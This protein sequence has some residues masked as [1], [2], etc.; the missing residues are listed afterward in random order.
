MRVTVIQFQFPVVWKSHY[1]SLSPCRPFLTAS[2]AHIRHTGFVKEEL[3]VDLKTW[4]C[5]TWR[6]RELSVR[7]LDPGFSQLFQ[8]SRD[9][10]NQTR[11]FADRPKIRSWTQECVECVEEANLLRPDSKCTDLTQE[12]S[13]MNPG[14]PDGGQKEE[15]NLNSCICHME[16]EEGQDWI[17]SRT[18]IFVTYLQMQ[19][20]FFHDPQFFG[21]S[22]SVMSR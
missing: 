5:L 20:H 19:Q 18:M 13:K 1:F 3:N 2:D 10:W 11:R 12:C 6:C 21:I 16:E 15:K 7:R 22:E 9:Y 8:E 17:D 14:T 4:I